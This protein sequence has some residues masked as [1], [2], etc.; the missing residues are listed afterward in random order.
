MRHEEKYFIW[1]GSSIGGWPLEE[2]SEQE[3]IPS[4]IGVGA[5]LVFFFIIF[6]LH[7]FQIFILEI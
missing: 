4:I 2:A 6:T 5:A 7:N 1:S 3:R